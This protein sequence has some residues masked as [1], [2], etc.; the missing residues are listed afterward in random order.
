MSMDKLNAITLAAALEAG[1]G[2]IDRK[3]KGA[4]KKEKSP[5]LAK[6]KQRRKSRRINRSK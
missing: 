5:K 3:L 4:P 2:Y 1:K 6:N